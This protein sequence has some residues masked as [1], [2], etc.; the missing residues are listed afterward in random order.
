MCKKIN[1]ITRNLKGVRDVQEN[2]WDNNK[3]K[4]ISKILDA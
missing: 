2:K 1:W 3:L 4:E